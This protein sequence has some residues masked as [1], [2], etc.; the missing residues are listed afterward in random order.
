MNEPVAT[1]APA[2]P[3][4]VLGKALALL[5]FLGM[6]A[7]L[8]LQLAEK[9]VD[10]ERLQAEVFPEAPPYGLQLAESAR[11]PSQDALVRFARPEAEGAGPH[12]VIFI[13][14]RN[15]AAVDAL[16][17]PP[18]GPSMGGGPPGGTS[19]GIPADPGMRLAEWEKTKAFDWHFTM[20]RGEI[21]W[22]TWRTKYLIERSFR[23][24]DGWYEEARVDLRSATRNLVLFAHWP[25]ETAI[26]DAAL[27]ELLKKVTL[28]GE[29]Q[30]L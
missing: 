11:L 10:G 6:L 27:R 15:R 4:G 25:R 14:Y 28:P 21:G 19:D 29:G 8:V 5:L 16:F 7:S 13:E 22:G 23:K 3:L 20:R 12:E 2:S 9:P 18:E 17:R 26:E 24:D 30:P 1:L